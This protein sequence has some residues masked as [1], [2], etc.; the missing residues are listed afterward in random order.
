MLS[1]SW[2][3]ATAAVAPTVVIPRVVGASLFKNG[4]AMVVREI[5]ARGGEEYLIEEMP[6]GAL[7]T[8]WFSAEGVRL[9]EVATTTGDRP[10]RTAAS[11]GDMLLANVG[12]RVRL[13]V[14][15][16]ASE[17]VGT[18]VS[19]E[20]DLVIVET[21]AGTVAFPKSDVTA[22]RGDGKKLETRIAESKSGLRIRVSGPGN[23]RIYLVAL[24]H[25]LTW[26]P[27][28]QIEVLDEKRLRFTGK[29]TIMNDLVDLKDVELR[30]VTG[31][32]NVPYAGLPDPLTASTTVTQFVNLIQGVGGN[33]QQLNDQGMAGQ[34][35]GGGFGGGRAGEMM[36]RPGQIPRNLSPAGV[37]DS[38]SGQQ[39]EDLF[40]FPRPSTSLGKGERS[41][42]TL[43]QAEVPFVRRYIWKLDR[44]QPDYTQDWY[45]QR[46]SNRMADFL[47]DVWNTVEFKN[48]SSQP[49]ST[50]VGILTNGNQLLGQSL[51][52]YTAKGAQTEIRVNKALDIGTDFSVEDIA[53]E[54]R[55]ENR[56]A[57]YTRKA[58]VTIRNGK[59]ETVHMRIEK[60]IAGELASSEVP[61]D[62]HTENIRDSY[63]Y[64]W[65]TY[66]NNP[67][68]SLS[69]SLD[70]K[71]AETKS[72]TFT[73]RVYHW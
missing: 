69:W 54:P 31:F 27:N 24:Q 57:F 23:G 64:G 7:G 70:L 61:V 1:M 43:F 26:A 73:Y 5:P 51:V 2:L 30:L 35:G 18:L 55:Q 11:I 34:M 25:G 4:Y 38:L 37:G 39:V 14:R 72:F 58:T 42:A 53:E 21:D 45:F 62:K 48:L 8:V 66:A 52:P 3:M 67:I 13:S 50:G 56:R 9:E 36:G 17:T 65:Y 32:P 19:A 10:G 40:F 6:P 22:V 47:P 16:P 33:V 59:S 63:W 15:N 20:G 41:Y 60:R 12:R 71:P 44:D 46:L 29:A 68:Q 49:L 28:Y